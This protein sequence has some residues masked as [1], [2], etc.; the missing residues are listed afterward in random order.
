M[1]NERIFEKLEELSLGQ[2]RIEL[3]LKGHLEDHNKSKEETQLKFDRI[4]RMYLPIFG[5]AVTSL[6]FILNWLNPH[7]T[8]KH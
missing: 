8:A 7:Y 5:T 2:Q 1:D 4:T 3:T 6:H